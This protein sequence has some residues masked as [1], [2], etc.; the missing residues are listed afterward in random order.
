MRMKEKTIAFLQPYAKELL[1]HQMVVIPFSIKS[2]H[3][4]EQTAQQFEQL[5]L[6]ESRRY[7]R[8][9]ELKLRDDDEADDGIIVRKDKK[10]DPKT[11]FHFRPGLTEELT[12][13]NVNFARYHSFLEHASGDY[14]TCNEHMLALA[15]ALDREAPGF[16]FHEKLLA[17]EIPRRGVYRILWYPSIGKK[18]GAILAQEHTDKSCITYHLWDRTAGLRYG[19]DKVQYLAEPGTVLVFWGKKAPILTNGLAQPL[20]HD[21]VNCVQAENARMASIFFGHTAP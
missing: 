7:I 5:L 10:H 2:I 13:R 14:Y 18:L 21:V 19:E 6:S 3:C 11:F 8:S 20:L 1:L 12:R 16:Y 17:S 4:F 15:A 9:W